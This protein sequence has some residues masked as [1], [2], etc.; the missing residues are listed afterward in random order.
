MDP[1]MRAL[2]RFLALAFALTLNASAQAPAADLPATAPRP[3]QVAPP[4]VPTI[5]PPALTGPVTYTCGTAKRGATKLTP[6]TLIS[7][8]SAGWDLKTVPTIADGICSAADQPFFFSIP[9]PPGNYR[10]TLAL[11]GKEASTITIRA[12][13]RRLYIQTLPVAAGKTVTRAFDVNVRIPEFTKPDG[14]QGRV[15]LKQ[16]EIGNLDWDAKL[17]LEFNG[18][19]PAFHWLTI[20]PLVGAKAEPTLYLAGDSTMVDQDVEP[21]A[22]WGQQLPR[23]F[24]P[25]VVVANHAESGESA[26]SFLGEQRFA[27]I[28]SL[29]KPGDYFFVQFAHNDQKIANGMPRYIQIMTD[30]V[31]QVR[32]KGAVPVI[33]TSMNRDSFDADGHITDTLGGYPQASREIAKDTNTA[34]IDLNAMSKIMFEA[35]GPAGADHAFMKFKAGS[36]PGVDRD[37]ADTTHFNNF[38]AY[39]LARCVVH[40]IREDKLPIVK[41]LDPSVPDFDPAHPDAFA[42]FRLPY[43]PP[44][45][46][47]D[48][49][50]IPQA[51]LK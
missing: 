13:A 11:G 31:T 8:T 21:W 42:D 43:T 33:V 29:I 19:N 3:V 23:F 47:G 41:F 7:S 10:V 22:S 14:T 50:Q 48:V 12:E 20:E 44:Q 39:E 15:R 17:T 38:G 6:A 32:A 18:V 45:Q 4:I 24:L 40:G 2:P 51:N 49:T 30:F 25:G 46:Q 35:M 1:F 37:I 16:R 28:L 26:I 9:V 34:L 36:Y 5:I 27:E